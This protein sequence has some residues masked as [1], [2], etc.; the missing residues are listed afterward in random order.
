MPGVTLK[1]DHREFDRTLAKCRQFSKRDP[2]VIVNT[3]AFYIARRAARETFKASP[4]AIR[5]YLAQGGGRVAAMIINKQRKLH[6][7][8]GLYGAEMADAIAKMEA[9]RIRSS[10]FLKSGWIPAIKILAALAEHPGVTTVR[11]ARQYGRAKGS[12]K[13]AT[14]G[15]VVKCLIENAV[16]TKWDRGG[17]DKYGLEALE[18]AFAFETGSMKAYIERKMLESAR[19]AGIAIVGA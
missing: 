13:P 5:A 17:H 3:K 2:A 4:S 10:G 9:T 12:A 16:G 1:F 19:K 14:N 18:R 7:Q 15:W 6:G 11:G 8:P